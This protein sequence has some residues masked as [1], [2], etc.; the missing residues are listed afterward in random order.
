MKPNFNKN[1]LNISA[2]FKN[3]LGG[4]TKIKENKKLKNELRKNYKNVI[5]LIFDGMG[6]QVLKDNL[7]KDNILRKN[8]KDILTSTYPTATVNATTTLATAD[9]PAN[10][11]W[12]GWSMYLKEMQLP[13][14]LFKHLNEI[15]DEEIDEKEIFKI[16]PEKLAYYKQIKNPTRKIYTIFASYA[17]ENLTNGKNNYTANDEKEIFDNIKKIL[18]KHKEEKFIYCYCDRPDKYMHDNG[19]KNDI[20]KNKLLE[21]SKN[22]EEI[23]NNFDDTLII[24]TADHG[25]IDVSEN[26]NL[27]EDE[28]FF[29][30]LDRPLSIEPRAISLKIKDGY[31]KEF[32]THFKKY[33]KDFKLVKSEKL[34]KQNFFGGDNEKLREFLGDYI[35]IGYKNP[36]KILKFYPHQKDFKGIHSGLTKAEL[37]V[38]M[39]LIGNKNGK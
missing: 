32:I 21:I 33:K 22:L 31:E 24:V 10:H 16:H 7:D 19:V 5:F 8:I 23:T 18:T 6:V 27:Y 26:I 1:I 12:L 2:T 30:M 25:H 39:I 28:K 29:S 14:V 34:I 9:Y 35:A 17:H 36:G 3:F 37:Y 38:P 4:N 13:I 20:V 11:L 15:T